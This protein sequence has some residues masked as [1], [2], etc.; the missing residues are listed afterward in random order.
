MRSYLEGKK[1]FLKLNNKWILSK[2]WE[3]EA[4]KFKNFLR[5]IIKK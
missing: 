4:K 5:I 2:N 3:N 1:N